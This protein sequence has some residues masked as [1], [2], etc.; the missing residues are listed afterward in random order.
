MRVT[1]TD[2]FFKIPTNYPKAPNNKRNYLI[3]K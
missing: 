2:K 1:G 3:I